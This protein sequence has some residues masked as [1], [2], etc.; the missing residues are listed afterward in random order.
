MAYRNSVQL[1]G[2]AGRDVEVR[3]T[4]DGSAVANLSLATTRKYKDA[5]GAVQEDTEW[6]K[7]VFFGRLAEVAS[8]YA[9][10]G[11]QIFVE[12]RLRTRKWQDKDGQD[13]YSTEIVAEDLQLLGR[14]TEEHRTDEPETVPL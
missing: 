9:K 4:A 1:I 2:H 3:F 11:R 6:H 7:V 13:R 8:E 12:G 10:K 5:S 14:H